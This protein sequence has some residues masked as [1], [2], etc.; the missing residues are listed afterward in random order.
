MLRKEI[1]YREHYQRL[2]VHLDVKR[3]KC[4]VITNV[5]VQ[6]MMYLN[7]HDNEKKMKKYPNKEI[8]H[9]SPKWEKHDRELRGYWGQNS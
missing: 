6:V 8:C 2:T 9:A 1:V 7:S 5:F 4:T 3:A